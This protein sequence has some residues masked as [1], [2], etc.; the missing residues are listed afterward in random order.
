MGKCQ[1]IWTI[2]HRSTKDADAVKQIC[3]DEGKCFLVPCATRWNS[4]YDAVCRVLELK[5]KL[6]EVCSALEL[7]KL[8]TTDVD[9]LTEYRR[10][11]QPL[12]PTLDALQEQN[13]CFYG[14]ILP[15]LI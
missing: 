8:K 5:D 15:K 14:I 13:D 3:S 4:M 12:A 10:V 9:F 1:A 11:L 7:P 2:V 6:N